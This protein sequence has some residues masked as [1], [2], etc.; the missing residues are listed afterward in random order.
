MAASKKQDI[1]I[2]TVVLKM[3]KQEHIPRLQRMMKRLNQGEKLSAYEIHDL[4][5]IYDSTMKNFR[6][7]ERNPEYMELAMRYIELYTDVVNKAV[8]NDKAK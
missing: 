8:E 1:Q 7:V 6:L 2:L 5:R 3:L 4:K